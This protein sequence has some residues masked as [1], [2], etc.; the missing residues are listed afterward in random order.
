MSNPIDIANQI[1]AA[2][3]PLV[4][5]VP[6]AVAPVVTAPVQ[7]AIAAPVALVAVPAIDPVALVA[8]A[9]ASGIVVSG[10]ATEVAPTA[11]TASVVMDHIAIAPAQPIAAPVLTRAEALGVAIAKE[12]DKIDAATKRRDLLTSQLAGIDKI[13]GI[14]AGCIIVAA[15]GRAETARQVRAVVTGVK[16]EGT[17]T[18][19]K[20]L[21]GE[22]F[23]ATTEVINESQVVSVE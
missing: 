23:D 17:S 7:L 11:G 12:Q 10:A 5:V 2:S 20:I 14:I 8:E 15:L 18:K 1:A 16:Q 9:A 13:S 21:V 4:A 6:V 22:G 3:Q 19:F